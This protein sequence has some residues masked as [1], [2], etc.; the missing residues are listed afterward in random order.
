VADGFP[1]EGKRG[2]WSDIFHFKF[3]EIIGY[4]MLEFVQLNE[5]K[6]S[7]EKLLADHERESAARL[8]S[9]ELTHKRS[10]SGDKFIR[11]ITVV[12]AT[13]LYRNTN[14][15]SDCQLCHILV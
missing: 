13:V 2:P 3:A 4:F 7:H 15:Y 1:S 8:A 14:E 5:L 12:A 11:S 10:L 6:Q 9:L